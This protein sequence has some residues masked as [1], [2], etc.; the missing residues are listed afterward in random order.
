MRLLGV[1]FWWKFDFFGKILPENLFLII[2]AF[3]EVKKMAQ[4]NVFKKIKYTDVR[5]NCILARDIVTKTGIVILAK[6]TMINSVNYTKIEQN[7]IEYIYVWED[8]IDDTLP[9][10]NQKEVYTLDEQTKSVVDKPEFKK[11]NESYSEN[12][13]DTKRVF[14]GIWKNGVINKGQLFEIT[15]NVIDKIS[16][17]SDI[18]TYL[19]YLKDINDYTYSHSLN[20][21]LLCNMFSKWLNLS[22]DETEDLTVAG[23]L[24]D[25]GKLKIDSKILNK[26]GKLTDEEFE[27]IK[28]HPVLGYEI[29]KD[30]NISDLIKDAVLMHHEK[31]NGTGYP[32]G[33]KEEQISKYA[34]IVSI[35]DIYDAMTSDRSYRNRI[36]PFTV[37][38]NFERQNFSILDTKYLFIFLQNIAY[39]YVG[40]WARLTNGKTAEIIFINQAQM[41]RPIVKSEDEFIDLSKNTDI[42]IEELVVN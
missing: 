33:L 8:S 42:D 31:I 32:S 17:K 7:E 35:C 38:R 29:I 26:K 4:E 9:P 10:F 37:I 22:E 18:F 12:L 16:C 5:P 2:Q 39:T 20:V 27:E 28:K 1:L 25:I 21:S 24:H 11:F 36:C 3:W 13:E 14:E 30:M 41:S 19:S 40:S 34:K 6:N 23:L 15:K